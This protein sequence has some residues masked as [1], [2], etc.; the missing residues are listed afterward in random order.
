[1]IWL[2]WGSGPVPDLPAFKQVY[3]LKAA[4]TAG[5]D[6]LQGLAQMMG[7]TVLDI[8]GVTDGLDN[9][10]TGQ[11]AG[12]LAALQ[13]HDLVVIHI[14]AAD[15]AGHAGLIDDKVEA[16][17]RVDQEILSQLRSWR[18]DSFRVL[19]MPDH[20]TPIQLYTHNDEPVP[21][22]LWGPGFTA[23]GAR[24]F[25]ESEAAKTGLFID[26]GYNIMSRLIKG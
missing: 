5:V 26:P 16:I 6:V 9:D 18:G 3:G 2:F 7:M 24:R 11:A 17:Q 19:V 25:T 21:F 12:T 20:P 1:M 23:N 10:F 4:M 22:M 14:E 15:D 8:P 13:E